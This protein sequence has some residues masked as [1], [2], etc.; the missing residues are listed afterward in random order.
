[1]AA[2]VNAA[3]PRVRRTRQLLEQAFMSLL[4]ERGFRDITV[5]DI[6]DRATV[7]R[8]TFYAHYTDKYDLLDSFIREGFRRGLTETLPPASSW[9]LN[10][11]RLLILAV[12]DFMAMV[13]HN[14]TPA[15]QEFDPFLERAVQQE[16]QQ[17]LA[18]WFNSPALNAAAWGVPAETIAT[19]WSWAIFG[20]ASQW[21]RGSRIPT[22][23]EMADHILAIL[24]RGLMGGPQPRQS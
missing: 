22:A 7:N 5:Q 4:A 12:F 14:C 2:Q 18:T 8:A 24:A 17:V 6:A 1:M 16:V 23:A 13:H 20:A 3:D 9:S 15:N 21:G 11:L 19:L 10:N